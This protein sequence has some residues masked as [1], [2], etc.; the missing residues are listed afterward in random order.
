MSDIVTLTNALATVMGTDVK[1][2][3]ASLAS[4]IAKQGDLTTL[5][6]TEKST[7]VGALNE[8]NS[9]LS[10]VSSSVVDLATIQGMIDTGITGLVDG[11]PD[12]LNTLNEIA[13]A[14]AEDDTAIDGV[15]AA[16]AKRVRVDAAQTFTDPEKAQGRDN[17]NAA[18][19]AEVGDVPNADFVATFNAA[20]AA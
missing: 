16:L 11:A 9:G 5:T 6:T 18:D 8:L 7:L 17:I 14:L 15:L 3:S 2:L 19:A 1:N 13:A 4:T 10:T 12:A 20:K